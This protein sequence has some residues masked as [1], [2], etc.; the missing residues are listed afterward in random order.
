MNL[1][2]KNA[3]MDLRLAY[4]QGNITAYPSD[5]KSMTG[6][7]STQYPNIKPTNQRGGKKRKKRQVND[8][9]FEDK[10]S[11][12]GGTAGVHVE[13]NTTNEDST[14][15][16]RRASLGL[17]SQEQIKHHPAHHVW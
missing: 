14:A 6:Y 11:N 12:T 2:N 17:T 8:S 9:K 1:K 13:D 16:S 3:K 4:S 10:D 7:L 5:I 15:P